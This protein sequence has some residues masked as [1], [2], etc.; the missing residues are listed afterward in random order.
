M[1]AE[2]FGSTGATGSMAE[3]STETIDADTIVDAGTRGVGADVGRPDGVPK[4]QGRFAFSSDLWA[5][6]FLWGH[7]LR[8]PH[9]SANI[10]DIDIGPALATAGVHAVLLADDVPGRLTYGLEHADQPVLA[11][12]VV[13]YCGA[14]PLCRRAGGGGGRRPPRH[15]PAGRRGHRGGLRGNRT[16]HRR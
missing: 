6:D 12:D 15:R 13:R 7:T 2:P 10:R 1:T 5:D 9:A 4:V 14:G 11:A 16:A 3:G 8:S